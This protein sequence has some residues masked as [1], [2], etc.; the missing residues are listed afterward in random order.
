LDSHFQSSGFKK[1]WKRKMP[2]GQ[3]T[4]ERRRKPFQL[5]RGATGYA[6]PKLWARKRPPIEAVLLFLFGKNVVA[7]FLKGGF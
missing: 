1:W 3:V 6:V 7:R 2:T 5:A 4:S